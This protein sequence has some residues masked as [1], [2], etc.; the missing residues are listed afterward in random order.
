MSVD[1]PEPDGPMTAVNRPRSNSTLMPARAWTTKSPLPYVLTRSIARAA[2]GAHGVGA[3]V[4]AWSV[5]AIELHP[6]EPWR[7][8]GP[9]SRSLPGRGGRGSTASTGR[10]HAEPNPQRLIR[11]RRLGLGGQTGDFHFAILKS[12]GP[13]RHPGCPWSGPDTP[14]G[15]CAT[16]RDTARA[17]MKKRPGGQAG[18][19]SRCGAGSTCAPTQRLGRPAA[20]LCPVVVDGWPIPRLAKRPTRRPIRSTRPVQQREWR[21]EPGHNSAFVGADSCSRWRCCQFWPASWS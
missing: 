13:C 12:K 11:T 14:S 19:G 1:L 8:H 21:A 2:G 7:D 17:G 4:G 20:C 10:S 6:L 3:P 16:P 9:W 5:I 18:G 15:P